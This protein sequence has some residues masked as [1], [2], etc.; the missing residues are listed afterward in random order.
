[1]S[2]PTDFHREIAA[3]VDPP[4]FEEVLARA[5]LR[6]RRRRT[7]IASSVTAAVLVAGV[8]W[9]GPGMLA[10]DDPDPAGPSP[11]GTS[12]PITGAVDERLPAVVRDLLGS[13][14]IDPRQ[15]AGSGGAIAVLWCTC[16]AD[17]ACRFAV[18]TRL[19]ERVTGSLLEGPTPTIAEVPDGW[20]VQDG[21]GTFRVSPDGERAPVIEPGGTPVPVEAGDTAVETA[22]GWRLLRGDKLI[23]MPT[24]DGTDALAAYVTPA[25]DLVVAT[26]PAPDAV[27]VSWTDASGSWRTGECLARPSPLG[28]GT[29]RARR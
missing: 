18:V 15:V 29:R 16:G 25:G 7:T 22:D 20:L 26:R 24:P 27:E 8:A 12:T 5:D 28:S 23:P 9:W 21:S 19:G 4:G 13:E 11:D 3:R 1:M 2:L 6:R 10:Q 17:D 14:R